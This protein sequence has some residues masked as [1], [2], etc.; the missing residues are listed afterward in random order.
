MREQCSLAR[1]E[2]GGIRLWQALQELTDGVDDAVDRLEWHRLALVAGSL[3]H[4]DRAVA[5]GDPIDELSDEGALADARFAMD[6]DE[7]R[8]LPRLGERFLELLELSF[9]T[10]EQR[11]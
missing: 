8:S 2:R 9:T 7:S 3:K 5:L 11:G 4:D 1:Q 6:R 10:D